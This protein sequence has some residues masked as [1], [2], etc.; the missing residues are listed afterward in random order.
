M[1]KPVAALSLLPALAIVGAPAA[2]AGDAALN[3]TYAAVSNG[4]WAM[5]NDVYRNEASVRSTWTIT[6]AC[7]DVVTCNGT[8]SS[9]AGWTA[10]IYTT[11]GQYVVK[12]ELP[13]WEPCADGRSFPGHQRFQFY[14]VDVVGGLPVHAAGDTKWPTETFAGVDRTSADSGNCSINE[15]LEIELPFRLEKLT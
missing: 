15:K 5:T 3:G 11:N 7:S 13:N 8:V 1:M 2:H 9:D 12:R 10:D 4:D 14:P 6:M